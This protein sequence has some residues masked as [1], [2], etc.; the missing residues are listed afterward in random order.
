M[1]Y[2]EKRSKRNSDTI[3]NQ[4]KCGIFLTKKEKPTNK[5]TKTQTETEKNSGNEKQHLLHR[6]YLFFFTLLNTIS[7]SL[8]LQLNTLTLL[9]KEYVEID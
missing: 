3:L 5:K 8:P 6:N 1:R 9:I 2:G 7:F 4:R